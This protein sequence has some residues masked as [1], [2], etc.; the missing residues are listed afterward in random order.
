MHQD[1]TLEIYQPAQ[2]QPFIQALWIASVHTAHEKQIWLPSDGAQGILFANQVD[3]IRFEQQ[4]FSNNYVIQPPSTQ[5][6]CITASNGAVI[7]GIRFTLGSLEYLR[8]INH[9]LLDGQ[10]LTTI[11][12]SLSDQFHLNHFKNLVLSHFKNSVIASRDLEQIHVLHKVLCNNKP[13]SESI[14]HMQ[15]SVRQLERYFKQHCK[16]TAKLL[17]RIIRVRLAQSKIKRANDVSLVDI[18]LQCGFS[19]QAHMSREFKHICQLSP[20]QYRKLI[21]RSQQC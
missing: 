13:L 7:A 6:H 10:T 21:S 8:S 11:S 4:S 5:S 15:V 16:I 19:D 2:A 9:P 1:L 12:S 20:I 17:E 3:N 14:N 18:A